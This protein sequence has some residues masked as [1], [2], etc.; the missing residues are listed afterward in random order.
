M[1]D[2]GVI[3]ENVQGFFAREDVED[4]LGGGLIGDVASESFGVTS[5]GA[6]LLRGRGAGFFVEVQ[7]AHRGAFLRETASD[8]Q[9]DA[10]GCTGNDS[11]FAVEAKR[12]AMF[13]RG[14]QRETPRFQGMKSFCASSSALV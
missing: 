4:L 10:A 8:G 1:R 6:D 11:D 14:A 12:V 13:R 5:A 3:H 7:D 2:A 9:T